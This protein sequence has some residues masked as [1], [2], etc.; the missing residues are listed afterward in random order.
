MPAAARMTDKVLHNSPH[1]H[2]PIHPNVPVPH[3]PQPF[4][5]VGATSPNVIINNLAA[6]TA[7]SMTEICRLAPCIP[8]GPGMVAMGSTSVMINGKPA[9]RQGDM[10][11]WPT[12]VGPIPSPTGKIIPPCSTDVDIGG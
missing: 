9:A 1:C 7:T 11:S 4:Q 5:I 2:A 3:P 6:A 12:C 8:A 10:V